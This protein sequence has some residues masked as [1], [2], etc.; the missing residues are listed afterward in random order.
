MQ[1][2]VLVWMTEPTA[3]TSLLTWPA[4]PCCDVLRMI[5]VIGMPFSA[6]N[7][8]RVRDELFDGNVSVCQIYGNF[9]LKQKFL[10]IDVINL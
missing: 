8:V 2:Q 9:V 5:L 4:K 10:S 6:E 7:T 3:L 1:L